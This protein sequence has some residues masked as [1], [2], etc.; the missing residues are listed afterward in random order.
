MAQAK[1]EIITSPT[2]P[3]C[4]SAKNAAIEFAKD[5]DVKV[6]ETSTYSTKG[7][8]RAQHL[9]VRSVPTMF[10]TSPLNPERIGFVG[11]PSQRQ[12]KKMVN[13]ALG[14]EEWEQKQ[15]LLSKI[16]KVIQNAS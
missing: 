10:I 9:G 5:N 13:I 3:H 14:K 6:I 15:G 1:I 4:P 7:Q 12:L 16:K 2:C 8:Q 11:V